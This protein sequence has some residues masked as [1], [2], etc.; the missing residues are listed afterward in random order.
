MRQDTRRVPGRREGQGKWSSFLAPSSHALQVGFGVAPVENSTE[1][2][3]SQTLDVLATTELQ[4]VAEVCLDIRHNMLSNA[5]LHRIQRVFS[6][7]QALAQCRGW[8]QVAA[9]ASYP[10]FLSFSSFPL[11]HPLL[12]PCSSVLVPAQ[13]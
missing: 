2:A 13:V 9:F 4:E 1:G 5:D 7:P 6:H 12:F 3:I 11:L 10:L 8:L